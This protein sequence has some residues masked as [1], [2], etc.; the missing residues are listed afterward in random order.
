MDLT[1]FYPKRTK[2]EIHYMERCCSSYIYKKYRKQ[3]YL[4]KYV[5]NV[6]DGWCHLI[7]SIGRKKYMCRNVQ[8]ERYLY[9]HYII[10]DYNYNLDIGVLLL[11]GGSS[12]EHFHYT[13]TNLPHKK[14][15]VT[16]HQYK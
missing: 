3:N 6:K 9:R 15:H 5:V 10:P 1:F 13:N 2:K 8:K 7:E 12:E 11:L 4:F 16:T 14:Y